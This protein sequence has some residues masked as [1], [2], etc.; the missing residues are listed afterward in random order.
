MKSRPQLLCA[1]ALLWHLTVPAHAQYDYSLNY[2]TNTINVASN[3]V[4]NV[5]FRYIVGSNTYLN[6]LVIQNS[7][8]LTNNNGYIG[9]ETGGSNNVAVVTGTGSVWS[10]LFDLYVGYAGAGNQLVVSNGGA[11]FNGS[12][13]FLG[14]LSFSSGNAAV[15][16]GTGSIWSNQS[17]LRV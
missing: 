13:G 8:G 6:A 11:V 1:V 16:T 15:V 3:W 17:D 7:G 5:N 12:V 2:Q 4:D 9:F 10:N 14:R